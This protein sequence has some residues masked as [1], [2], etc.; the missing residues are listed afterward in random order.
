MR[1][2][3]VTHYLAVGLMLA[4]IAS[5]SFTTANIS[6]LKLS[7]DKEGSAQTNSFAPGDTV[8]AIATVSNNPGKVTLKFQLIAEKVEGERENFHVSN[9]DMSLEVDGDRTATYHVEPPPAGWPA[10]RY[11]IEVAM[12]TEKGEQ[13]DQETGTFTVS[14]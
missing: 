4:T 13:K 3:R 5:C 14:K 9:L 7:K 6:S 1:L 11:R 8:Y 10:G 2:R 12:L